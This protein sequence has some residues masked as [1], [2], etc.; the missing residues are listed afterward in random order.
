MVLLESFKLSYL[1]DTYEKRVQSIT[2]NRT[3]VKKKK[4]L[5]LESNPY[6]FIEL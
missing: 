5:D 2:Q 1:S 4:K 6:R 3:L